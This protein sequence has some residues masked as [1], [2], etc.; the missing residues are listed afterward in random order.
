M[1]R[2]VDGLAAVRAAVL[3][4]ERESG[5]WKESADRSFQAWRAR[6]SLVGERAAAAQVRQAEQLG[7]VPSV[8]AAVSA[9][10]ISIDHAATIGRVAATGTPAP[11]AAAGSAD[12]QAH[13]LRIA[14]EQD[15]GTFATTVARW[16]ATV[17]PAGLERDHQAQRRARVLHLSDTPA[18]TVIKGQVDSMAGHRLRLALEASTPRPGVEDD[19]DPGQRRADALDAM[20]GRI[21]SDAD[22]K[23]GAHVPPHVSMILTEATWHAARAERDRERSETNGAAERRTATDEDDRPAIADGL[24][25][26]DVAGGTASV[27]AGL[28]AVGSPAAEVSILLGGPPVDPGTPTS[29]PAGRAGAIDRV[30]SAT[31]DEPATLEDGTPVPSSELARVMCDCEIT[32]IVVDAEGAPL[33]L[34]RTPRLFTE[35]QRRAVIARDRECA[36]PSCHAPARWCDVHHI[37]WWDR[38]DGPTSVDSE[39]CCAP[40][41]TTRSTDATS[42]SAGSPNV[43]PA[44]DRRDDRPQQHPLRD[45][46]S[47][48]PP[49]ASSAS[50]R[51]VT[52]AAASRP[53][54]RHS[55]G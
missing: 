17:D 46:S 4:A 32:R 25:T 35:P 31:G 13:L 19:R 34:G 40:T 11:Q 9:G 50:R 28:R 18:G 38:D 41:T 33:D 14:E 1:D 29:M 23:P 12:G 54:S 49:D 10:R 21:L 39:F 52:R 27:A 36:W 43:R 3:L 45:T 42:R 55:S 20:V 22:T 7:A 5:A 16:A 30:A 26:P 48:T 24:R 44:A 47:A 51:N 37:R 6:T 8:A 15:A 53:T 2:A